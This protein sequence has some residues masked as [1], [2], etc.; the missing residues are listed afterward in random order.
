MSKKL[1]K[2]IRPNVTH[3]GGPE[4]QS[5]VAEPVSAK[6]R[7]GSSIAP[8]DLLLT[9][10]AAPAGTTAGGTE[11]GRSARAAGAP[12]G[13]DGVAEPLTETVAEAASPEVVEA[14]TSAEAPTTNADQEG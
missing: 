14:V 5:R 12:G 9:T 4:A 1:P 10:P 7:Q 8:E 13:P 11:A 6:P 2:A 3:Q